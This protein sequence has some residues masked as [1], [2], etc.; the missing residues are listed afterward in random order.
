MAIQRGAAD[1]DRVG[2]LLHRVLTTVEHVASD[3]Q[4]VFGDDRGAPAEPTP[5]ARRL[6]ARLRA[7]TDQL[8]LELRDRPDAVSLKKRWQPATLSASS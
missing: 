6:Q 7:L 2:D 8:A 1:A 4:L 5:S 3:A